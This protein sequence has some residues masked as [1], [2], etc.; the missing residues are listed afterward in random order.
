MATSS[1]KLGMLNPITLWRLELFATNFF[2]FLG[3]KSI[4]A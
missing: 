2:E 1:T 4:Y 3:L